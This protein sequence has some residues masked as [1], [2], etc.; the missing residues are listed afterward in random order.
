MP[1]PVNMPPISLYG[2]NMKYA[3]SMLS[4]ILKQSIGDIK[5]VEHPPVE[6]PRWLLVVYRE[7]HTGRIEAECLR[8]PNTL[9][10]VYGPNLA[11]GATDDAERH[12]GSLMQLIVAFDKILTES[13]ER[14]TA[15]IFWCRNGIDFP[16]FAWGMGGPG[17]YNCACPCYSCW[18]QREKAFRP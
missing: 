16:C 5:L 6:P 18:W 9:V 15:E 1:E 14:L 3:P 2:G 13:A 4:S 10:A 11:S 17:W 7:K 12:A 8:R